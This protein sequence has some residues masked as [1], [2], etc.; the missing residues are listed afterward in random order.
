VILIKKVLWDFGIGKKYYLCDL[1]SE[2][3][4]KNRSQ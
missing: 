1:N 4:N 2:R 3:Y